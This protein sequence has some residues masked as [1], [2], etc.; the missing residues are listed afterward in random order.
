MEAIGRL[1]GGVAH[2]FN[3]LLTVINGYSTMALAD[4]DPSEPHHETLR[5]ILQAGE[6]AAGLTRQLLA[7]TRMQ[8]QQTKAWDLNVIVGDMVPMLK[9]L[10]GEDARLE[11]ELEPGLGRAR[12][13]RGQVEQILLNLVVNA[14]DAMPRSGRIVIQT[15]NLEFDQAY[16]SEH[17][18]AKLGPHV[19]LAV[20]DT[21]S[22]MTP[23]VLARL[24]EPFF[25]TKPLGKGTGLGLSV[26]YGIVKQ[27]G[28]S[29]SVDSQL[30]IGS[31]FRVFFPAIAAAELASLPPQVGQ[32]A[33]SCR[34]NEA[35]LLVE[36]ADEVRRFAAMALECQGYRVTEARNGVEAL[37]LLQEHPEIAIVVTD[38]VMPDM[39]GATLAGLIR[40][41]RPSVPI[42][43]MSGF[44]EHAEVRDLLAASE[45]RILQKPFTPFG[46][47]EKVRETLDAAAALRASGANQG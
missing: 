46:L 21:G 27:S 14:R 34:G 4:M 31:S 13:D 1:A 16:V 20:T 47:A 33:A 7:H 23:E 37:L 10:I 35:V 38:V 9:R 24:F 5:E 6:R 8:V 36:D 45:E 15:G 43:F 32:P 26:V 25:T 2:D 19:M 3:N 42:V 22:G 44:A 18:G 28:G 17:E 41:L 11:T 30:G 29:L 39:G 12:V 40:P